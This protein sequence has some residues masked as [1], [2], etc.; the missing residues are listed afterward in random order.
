MDIVGYHRNRMSVSDGNKSVDVY[1]P[2]Q[3]TL[4]SKFEGKI[5]L[6][7]PD[8][9]KVFCGVDRQLW[10]INQADLDWVKQVDVNNEICEKCKKA[11]IKFLTENADE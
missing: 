1:V 10:C 3:D 11:A 2:R 4:T 6:A 8:N 7:T 5:H 9:S